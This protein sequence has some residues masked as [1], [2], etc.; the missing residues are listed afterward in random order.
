MGT[1]P[2]NMIVDIAAAVFWRLPGAAAAPPA[3]GGLRGDGSPPQKKTMYQSHLDPGSPG[4]GSKQWNS[5][6]VDF[7]LRFVN[8]LENHVKHQVKIEQP[9]N[10]SVVTE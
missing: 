7:F 5:L 3:T 6:E 4:P 8:R 9:A 1:P 2:D 10:K